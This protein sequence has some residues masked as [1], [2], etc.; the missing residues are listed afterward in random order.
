MSRIVLLISVLTLLVMN[1]LTLSCEA[2]VKTLAVLPLE[3]ISEYDNKY[4]DINPAEIMT[5][6]LSTT[7]DKSR[8]YAIIERNKRDMILGEMDSQSSENIDSNRVVEIGKMLNVQ[9][10]IVGKVTW[11]RKLRVK[12]RNQVRI[13]V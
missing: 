9:N 6:E 13:I 10:V 11:S 7:L 2:K 8:Q 1:T 12:A 5:E 3:D 4:A